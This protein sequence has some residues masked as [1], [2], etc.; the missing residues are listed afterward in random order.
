AD[1][2]G[3]HVGGRRHRSRHLDH[4]E[5]RRELMSSVT[6]LALPNAGE[7]PAIDAPSV[8]LVGV[9]PVLIMFGAAVL[10]VVVE[11]AVPRSRRHISQV[12]LAIA[13]ILAAGV[14]TVVLGVDGHYAITF[15]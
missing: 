5:R 13:G 11:A 14:A 6:A 10:A 8:D 15:A 4:C 2:D 9:L 12:V 7:L 1:R 3:D